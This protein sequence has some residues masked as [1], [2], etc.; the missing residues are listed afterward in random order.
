MLCTLVDK[1]DRESPLTTHFC[2][3]PY[4]CLA[5]AVHRM[6]LTWSEKCERE[7][8]VPAVR[9]FSD[10]EPDHEERDLNAIA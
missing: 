7:H 3:P 6:R 10:E 4:A 2:L 9:T 8:S 1:F 5:N